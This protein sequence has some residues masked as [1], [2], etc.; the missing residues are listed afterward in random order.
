I[1]AARGIIIADTKFEFGLTEPGDIGNA[2]SG[3]VILVDEVL[4][5]D[6]SR[7]WPADKYRPGHSQPSFDKQ[8]LRDYLESERIAG[9]WDGSYPPPKLPRHVI[10]A[11]TS[12]YLDIYRRLTGSP[13]SIKVQ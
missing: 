13:L 10:E 8:P 7:F 4:T 3:T 2:S 12:R 6:S 9:R 1:A 5:P 11:T